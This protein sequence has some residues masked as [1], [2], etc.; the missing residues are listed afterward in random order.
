M[1]WSAW[2][3]PTIVVTAMAAIVISF[4]FTLDFR[5]GAW[6]DKCTPKKFNS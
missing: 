4:L 2:A 1:I 5:L 6:Q 3:L